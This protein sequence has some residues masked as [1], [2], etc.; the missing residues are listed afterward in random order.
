MISDE[1]HEE[2]LDLFDPEL[3]FPSLEDEI[4]DTIRNRDTD[5]L[6]RMVQ[7]CNGCHKW[8]LKDGT[9]PRE[10]NKYRKEMKP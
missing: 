7:E 2:P 5:R 3:D 9:R 1:E 4:W 6:V 10:N 8:I